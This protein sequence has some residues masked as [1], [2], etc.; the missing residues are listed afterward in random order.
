MWYKEYTGNFWKSIIISRMKINQ[1]YFSILFFSIAFVIMPVFCNAAQSNQYNLEKI[2]YLAP[3]NAVKGVADVNKNYKDMDILAPQYFVVNSDL[4]VT[5][6]FGPQLK[7]AIKD[8]NLKVMPLVAN[9]HFS[10]TTI[11]NLLI[12]PT[13]QDNIIN[14]LISL[15]KN[16][17]FIGWQF[18]F[19]H[20]NYQDKDLYT[21]FVQKAYP[22][23]P[24]K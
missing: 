20:I 17:N 12:S 1:K 5:G 14:T 3:Y 15:A 4:S 2:F 22:V 21:A 18:D 16:Q 24:K 6:S 7:K 8:H 13:A 23:V 10:Q 11:H 19:E 9:A